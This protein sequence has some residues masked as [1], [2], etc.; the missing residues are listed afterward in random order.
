MSARPVLRNTHAPGRPTRGR[1]GVSPAPGLGRQTSAREQA[2]A[3]PRPPC[4][5]TSVSSRRPF[6]AHPPQVGRR[7]SSSLPVERQT[8]PLPTRPS[9]AP[10]TRLRRGRLPGPAS[11][12]CAGRLT[13]GALWRAPQA[14][15]QDRVFYA[16]GAGAQPFFGPEGEFWISVETILL[17]LTLLV[18]YPSPPT[19]MNHSRGT[20]IVFLV[21][22]FPFHFI[23]SL[24][25][26]L[27]F[28]KCHVPGTA[29]GPKPSPLSFFLRH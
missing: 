23:H 22:T 28:N 2:R 19:L 1:L 5:V 25:Q 20:P 7:A 14:A 13:K 8:P 15:P 17:S 11:G 6:S 24:S 3:G 16:P 10:R 18:S 9:R 4:E 27:L 26:S 12:S 29:L 21:L